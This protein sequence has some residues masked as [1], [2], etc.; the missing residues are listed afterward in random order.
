M[1]KETQQYFETID[2]GELFKYFKRK[3]EF[4]KN[5]P[6]DKGY[7]DVTNNKVFDGYETKKR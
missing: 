2:E 5:H 3:R 1:D 6:G 4:L 7:W